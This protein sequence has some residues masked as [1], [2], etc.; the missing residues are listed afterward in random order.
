MSGTCKLILQDEVNCKFEGLAPNI[1]QEMI[2]KV[3]FTLPYAKFTPAGRMGR[4]DGK[5]NFMNIGGST[6]YHMLDQLLPILE[7]A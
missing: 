5:V 4:W 2:R 1:R 3:S 7:N 6:H